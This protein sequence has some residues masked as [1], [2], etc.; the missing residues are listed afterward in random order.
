MAMKTMKLQNIITESN[1]YH[2]ETNGSL[3]ERGVIHALLVESHYRSVKSY[4]LHGGKNLRYKRQY[5]P[6]FSM[7]QL[8]ENFETN[9]RIPK[10]IELPS[11][12][13]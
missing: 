12:Y 3:K 13:F 1:T 8:Q 10:L 2:P 4:C 6:Q 5:L 9:F 11:K 7:R